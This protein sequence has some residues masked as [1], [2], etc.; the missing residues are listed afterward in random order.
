MTED[1]RR[2]QG[3]LRAVLPLMM[4]KK[5]FVSKLYYKTPHCET[6]LSLQLLL[7]AF[8]SLTRSKNQRTFFPCGTDGKS[9]TPTETERPTISTCCLLRYTDLPPPLPV[10]NGLFVKTVFCNVSIDKFWNNMVPPSESIQFF[11]SSDI[12]Y[13]SKRR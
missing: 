9:L 11:Y 10:K 3:P 7:S 2:D 5:Y 12:E 8:C 13:S 6:L 4:K 1:A